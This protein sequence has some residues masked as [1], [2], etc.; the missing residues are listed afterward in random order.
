MIHTDLHIHSI[1][2]D[3]GEFGPIDIVDRC[4]AQQVELFSL[5]DHNSVRGVSEAAVH[6]TKTGIDFISGIEIDCSYKGINLHVL[7]YSIQL[8]SGDFLRLEEDV[9]AKVMDSLDHMIDN[10][11]QLGFVIDVEAVL[12]KAKGALPSG[13]LTAEVMLND[14]RYDS[15][16][17]APY[18]AG[19]ERGDMPYLNF[20]LDY[21]AQGKSAFVPIDYI[22]YEEAV[23]MIRDNGGTP[24]LAHPGLNLI[25]REHLAE[26]LLNQ[27]IDGLEVFNNY[28]SRNQIAYFMNIV[29]ER[30]K[31][32]TCGSDFHGK[33][34]PLI[35]IGQFVFEPSAAD[36]LNKSIEQ[37]KR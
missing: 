27:G 36:Y 22:R 19:G 35:E 7:G 2:S 6:A 14:A 37:L 34:K 16:L 21:F 30:T 33:N 5:T 20:Y 17:L 13:E 15:P 11:N 32:M 31:V 3:D 10:L 8:E 29:Q 9:A 28:H 24:I 1:M 12:A 25:G 26:E 18:R 4:L 23:A